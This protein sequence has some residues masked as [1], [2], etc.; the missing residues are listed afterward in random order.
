MKEDSDEGKETRWSRKM[1]KMSKHIELIK[2]K[3]GNI[4]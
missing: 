2:T 1:R 3:F 4:K